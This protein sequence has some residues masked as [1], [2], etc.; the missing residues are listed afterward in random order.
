[1]GSYSHHGAYLNGV[2]KPEHYVWRGMLAR[3]C[4]PTAKDYN[5]YGARGIEVCPE[6]LD[7]TVFLRDMGPRPSPLH[8]VERL[9]NDGPYSPD[10]CI[11]ATASMQQKNK[12]T[13]KRYSNGEFTGTLS[14]CATFLGISE[15]LAH[16]RYKNWGSFERNVEWRLRRKD[17]LSSG[18]TAC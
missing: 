1:M 8:S 16:W 13:T 6:W 18:S 5:R 3:C 15:E 9:D 17:V 2:E 4:R 10:N 7:Y 12:S 14:E 11:W